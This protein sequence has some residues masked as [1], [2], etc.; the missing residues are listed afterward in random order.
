MIAK[1]EARER[2]T[3]PLQVANARIEWVSDGAPGATQDEEVSADRVRREEENRSDRAFLE[4]I[5]GADRAHGVETV[6]SSWHFTPDDHA[7]AVKIAT[8][9]PAVTPFLQ[10]RW[11]V[12]GADQVWTRPSGA[13]VAQKVRVHVFD[14]TENRL[15]DVCVEN[16][17]VVSVDER[18]V[19]EY[20]ES[21]QEMGTAI[22]LARWH[23]DLR[24]K[25]RDLVGHAI[26]RVPS[27]PRDPSVAR[28]CMWVMFTERDDPMRQLPTQ[29]TALVDLGAMEVIMAGPTPCTS[30]VDDDHDGTRS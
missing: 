28:R 11:S 5:Y 24:D 19:H 14:Y 25:V 12:L 4:R 26:L 9:H 17:Q 23:P 15:I 2:V 7:R 16:D 18:G 10:G 22:E 3:N 27:D 1:P 21:P 30:A 6:S 29:Y 20:P 13:S 8:A